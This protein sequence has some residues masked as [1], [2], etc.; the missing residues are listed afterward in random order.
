[1]S[2]KSQVDLL[3]VLET[4]TF[5]R[6]GGEE[7]LQTEARIISAT[8][9]STQELIDE[10]KFREDLFYRL[11]VIPIEV[12]PLRNRREDIPL[13]V[14]HF[15]EHFSNRHKRGN[16]RIAPDAMHTLVQ[17]PWPGNVRQLRNVIERMVITANGE[18]IKSEELPSDFKTVVSTVPYST[19][20][21]TLA[22]AVEVCEKATIQ[23]AL[24]ARNHHRENTAK[25][26][27]VSVRT[28]HYKM[29]R[30]G[31]H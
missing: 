19:I 25:A 16:M 26:L 24:E 21:T 7:L 6:V 10:G 1:M 20:P 22:D 4:R 14:E 13:L 29:S 27:G 31:L 18:L 15:L 28:L 8:N 9:R 5:T 3:R 11:N 30:Y 23:A 2:T 12:P 17:A